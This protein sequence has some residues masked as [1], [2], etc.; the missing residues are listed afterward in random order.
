[1]NKSPFL[2]IFYPY[3][4]TRALYRMNTKQGHEDWL[5]LNQ[6]CSPL[7]FMAFLNLE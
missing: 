5:T 7:A 3:T 4:C 2:S 1:M 6:T